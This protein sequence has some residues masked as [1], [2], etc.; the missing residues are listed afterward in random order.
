VA[1]DEVPFANDLQKDDTVTA[2]AGLSNDPILV[3]RRRFEMDV[4]IGDPRERTRFQFLN[5]ALPR[6]AEAYEIN[7]VADAYWERRQLPLPAPSAEE[8]SLIE[9]MNQYVRPRAH[10]SREGKFFHVR[11]YTWYDDRVREIPERL[12]KHWAAR[13]REH[14]QLSLEDAAAIALTFRNEQIED[15]EAVMQHEGIGFTSGEG[16]DYRFFQNGVLRYKDILRAYAVLVPSQR[17]TLDAGGALPYS[18]MSPAARRWLHTAVDQ[19]L[20][21]PVDPHEQLSDKLP[22][23]VTPETPPSAL[24]LSEAAPSRVGGQSWTQPLFTLQYRE[25][26]ARLGFSVNLPLIQ[27]KPAPSRKLEE[28]SPKTRG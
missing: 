25:G 2:P 20:R 3:R 15:F 13:L 14:R 1:G 16:R 12:I 19:R 10:W 28:P 26:G 6:I 27:V 21:L 11:R 18:A 22:A 5:E 24:L 7:L 9:T 17:Q 23:G 8:R 4:V